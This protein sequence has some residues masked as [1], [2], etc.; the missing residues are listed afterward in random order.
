[1]GEESFS[2]SPLTSKII[3]NYDNVPQVKAAIALSAFVPCAE[4]A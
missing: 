2:S 3:F 4:V 1:M